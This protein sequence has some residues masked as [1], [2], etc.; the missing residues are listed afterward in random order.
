MVQKR[1]GSLLPSPRAE[2]ER[3]CPHA[4]AVCLCF[5]LTSGSPE[6]S[7]R[8]F[9][10][11]RESFS[12]LSMYSWLSF[13][14]SGCFGSL[15]FSWVHS[16][17]EGSEGWGSAQWKASLGLRGEMP[18]CPRLLRNSGTQFALSISW[19]LKALS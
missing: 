7:K 6:L 13:V 9:L 12:C 4:E 10:E 15:V 5:G 17:R 2:P 14:Y 3:V 19:L 11:N 16:G 1:K 18:R 8:C